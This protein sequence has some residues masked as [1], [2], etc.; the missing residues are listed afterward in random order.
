VAQMDT[1]VFVLKRLLVWDFALLFISLPCTRADVTQKVLTSCEHGNSARAQNL[2][3]TGYSARTDRSGLKILQ[4]QKGLHVYVSSALPRVRTER[5]PGKAMWK[6]LQVY[7]TMCAV[8]LVCFTY[9]HCFCLHD[10]CLL[11][12]LSV[13]TSPR[14]FHASVSE[15]PCSSHHCQCMTP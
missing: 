1:R 5:A 4:Q 3:G 2:L 6:L 7:L 10:P 11:M 15:F 12:H 9:H 14:Y 8:Q 13:S